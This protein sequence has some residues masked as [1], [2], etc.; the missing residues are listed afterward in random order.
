MNNTITYK[1]YTGSI[2]FDEEDNLFY[3][4]VLGIRSLI[5][6]EGKDGKELVQDFHTSIDEYLDTCKRENIKPEIAF[7]GS[8]NVRVSSE[9]HKK[10]YI[11]ASQHNI[12]MNKYIE[13]ILNK[14][15]AAALNI[16]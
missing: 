15:D 11:Y 14:S 7:K 2:E 12:S 3:G 16:F 6:Y 10:L 1:N 13:D 9:L 4:K 5:S 8:F